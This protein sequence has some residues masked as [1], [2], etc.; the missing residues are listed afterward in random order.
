M[1]KNYSGGYIQNNTT[2]GSFET[3]FLTLATELRGNPRWC[4]LTEE[5]KLAKPS[6]TD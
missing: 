1:I 3:D 5:L 6:S 4:Q 2:G